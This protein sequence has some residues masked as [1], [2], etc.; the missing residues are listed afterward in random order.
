MFGFARCKVSVSLE[1][2]SNI[3]RLSP[4]LLGKMQTFSTRKRFARG[5]SK[6]REMLAGSSGD[7][8][9][10]REMLKMFGRC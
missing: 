9:D 7:V 3:S 5:I 6:K 8:K 1:A 4:F 10:V 2:L